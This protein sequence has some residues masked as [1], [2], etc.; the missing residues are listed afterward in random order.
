MK[1]QPPETIICSC[2]HE[3]TITQRTPCPKCGQV[4]QSLQEIR[5]RKVEI[6]KISN[7]L[8]AEY[9]LLIAEESIRE[10][11]LRSKTFYIAPKPSLHVKLNRK[12]K[13][14]LQAE[15]LLKGM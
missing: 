11:G 10:L 5:A 13:L 2:K 15:M 6:T 3:F 1:L 14:E 12:E 7:Q 8:S 4:F 9:S